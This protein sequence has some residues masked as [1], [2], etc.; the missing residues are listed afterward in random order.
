[1]GAEEIMN[2]EA[3]DGETLAVVTFSNVEG[4]DV[5][6][7]VIARIRREKFPD[8]YAVDKAEPIPE[9]IDQPLDAILR[10]AGSAL[11]NYSMP[12]MREGMR[13]ALRD[14]IAAAQKG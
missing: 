4:L 10:A 6:A 2:R 9:F 3:H 12:L 1:M 8:A 14:A 11:K 13:K 5:L 7:E